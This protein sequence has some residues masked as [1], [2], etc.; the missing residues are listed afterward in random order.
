MNNVNTQ[1]DLLMDVLQ[2]KVQSLQGILTCTTNQTALLERGEFDFDA[3][4]NLMKEKEVLIDKV[5]DMDEGFQAIYNKVKGI[6]EMQ[7]TLYKEKIQT[8]KQ[9][10]IKIGD[11]S[12]AITVQEGRNKNQMDLKAKTDKN[13]GKD[14]S[15]NKKIV[16]NYYSNMNKQRLVEQARSFDSKK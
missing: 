2:Q 10:I 5:I 13:K 6:I 7:P 14:F 12:V 3:F 4:D 8:M 16:A 15:H 11:L 9:F 1:L